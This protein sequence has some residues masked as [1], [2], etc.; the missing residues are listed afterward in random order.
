[1]PL[2]NTNLQLHTYT[3]QTVKPTEVC[4]VTVNYEEQE[5]EL[6][7]CVVPGDGPTLLGRE[8]L[9]EIT[10]NWKLLKLNAMEPDDLTDVLKRDKAVFGDDWGRLKDIKAKFLPKSG[11]K[12]TFCKPRP[13]ALARKEAIERELDRLEAEWVLEKV[14][15]SDWAAPIVTPIKTDGSVRVCSNLTSMLMCTLCLASKISTQD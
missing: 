10:L 13:V 9:R 8:L 12:P 7:V 3:G 11:A 1:V 14:T 4:T 2:K 5:K 6:L 15:H